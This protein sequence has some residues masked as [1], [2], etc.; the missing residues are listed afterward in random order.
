MLETGINRIL[1]LDDQSGDRLRRLDDR[2]LRLD[3][4]GLGIALFFAF[5]KGHVEVGT[6]SKF[7]PD[8]VIS[9]TLP[10]LFRMAVPDEAGVW[11]TRPTFLQRNASCAAAS[12]CRASD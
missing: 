8:T 5:G 6:D 3:L 7:E 10:A 9:G 12:F 2:M 11:G 4:E 1:A